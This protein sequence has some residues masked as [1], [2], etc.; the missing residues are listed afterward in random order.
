M[1][2]KKVT[3]IAEI[4]VNHNG[5]LDLAK[6]LIIAAKT[7]GADVA[8]FQYFN[9]TTLASPSSPLAD[10]QNKGF[11]GS[12]GGKQVSMLQRLQFSLSDFD[13]L[14]DLCLENQIEFGLSFFDHEDIGP[15]S[16]AL[17]LQRV[18]VPSG[19]I[20]NEAHLRA[21]ASLGVPIIISTGM[22]SIR[23]IEQAM[24][25]VTSMGLSKEKVTLLQCTS[26]Y[27]TPPDEMNVRVVATLR[28]HFGVGVGL[29]DHSDGLSAGCLSV[30]F[31]ATIVEKH[32]TLDRGMDGPDHQASL[33][34]DGFRLYCELIRRAEKELGNGKKSPTQAELGNARVVRRSPHARNQI[35]RG[36]KFGPENILLLRPEG[37][38]TADQIGLLYGKTSSR[39]YQP[40]EP[41]LLE[42]LQR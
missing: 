6:Q 5:S 33:D 19:E 41:I 39:N 18:K 21:A 22:A 35:S 34:P 32:L 27:P 30:A 28:E 24:S 2:T 26:A 15:V 12:D 3:V 20:N 37:E 23:E 29:S 10:Y 13:V 11:G 14:R 31:G 42:E 17:G 25:W 1:T 16:A 40:G 38:I 36:Q 4:G 7:S 9:A 8:K